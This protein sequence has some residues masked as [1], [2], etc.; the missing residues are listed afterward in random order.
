MKR[1]LPWACIPGIVLLLLASYLTCSCPGFVSC[2]FCPVSATARS[3]RP[4][5]GRSRRQSRCLCIQNEPPAGSAALCLVC[6]GLPSGGVYDLYRARPVDDA[7]KIEIEENGLEPARA[8]I[9]AAQ[10]RLRPI[11]LTTCT[12]IGGMLPLWYGGGPMFEP[13]AIAIIFG[14]LFATGLTLGVVPVLYSL[15]FRVRFKEFQY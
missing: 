12:T 11:L 2:R 3:L 10:R 7:L 5:A 15:L 1:M 4:I 6:S 14:L 8:V 9:E 13:M